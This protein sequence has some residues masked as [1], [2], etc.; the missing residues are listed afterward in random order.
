MPAENDPQDVK[1]YY[2]PAAVFLLLF[3]VLGPLGLPFLYKS[4]KFNKASKIILTILTV[5]YTWYLVVKTLEI[6]QEASKI[7]SDLQI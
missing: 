6:I 5:V 4:P 7:I 3:L 1:W 2:R